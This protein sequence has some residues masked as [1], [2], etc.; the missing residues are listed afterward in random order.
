MFRGLLK[1][2]SAYSYLD[3]VLVGDIQC[4]AKASVLVKPYRELCDLKEGKCNLSKG[5]C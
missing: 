5:L 4:P 2:H 3:N 1:E